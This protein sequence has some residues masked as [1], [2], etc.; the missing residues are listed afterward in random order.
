M[1]IINIYV[2][3]QNFGYNIGKRALFINFYGCNRK[4]DYCRIFDKYY[5]LNE[6]YG[7][8]GF[9]YDVNELLYIVSEIDLKHIVLTGGEPTIQEDIL[10]L[11]QELTNA[12]YIVTMETNAKKYHDVYKFVDFLIVNIKTYSA[13]RPYT[14]LKIIHQ[15]LETCNWVSFTCLIDDKKDFDYLLDKFDKQSVWCFLKDDNIDYEE[16]IDYF[17]I[18]NN[19]RMCIKY[20]TLL[21]LDWENNYKRLKGD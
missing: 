5:Y 21:R 11:V 18:N 4:C 12:G 14:D 15:I 8:K 16:Y 17:L 6:G 1:N 19:L 20:D 13:G 9:R 7:L 3:I 2:G 10:E